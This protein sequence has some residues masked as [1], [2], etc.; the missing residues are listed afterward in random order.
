MTGW[1]FLSRTSAIVATVVQGT[2]EIHG[3]TAFSC[4][5]MRKNNHQE[6]WKIMYG[7]R[8]GLK[9]FIWEYFTQYTNADVVRFLFFCLICEPLMHQLDF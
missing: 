7:S 9:E 1:K 8:T 4:A 3:F 5:M 6:V 2:T